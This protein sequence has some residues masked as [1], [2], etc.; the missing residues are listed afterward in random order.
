MNSK[1]AKALRKQAGY[2]PTDK[3]HQIQVKK[4]ISKTET[5]ILRVENDPESTR[6]KYRA[7]KAAARS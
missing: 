1:K 7:L 6:A 3:R 2:H 4:L 5:R